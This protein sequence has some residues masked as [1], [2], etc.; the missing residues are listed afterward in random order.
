M[1]CQL[2][3]K[4]L[5]RGK[6]AIELVLSR[7]KNWTESTE[8]MQGVSVSAC[9]SALVFIF[10][11]LLPLAI[12]CPDS[13][14][15]PKLLPSLYSSNSAFCLFVCKGRLFGTTSWLFLVKW[16]WK[17]WKPTNSAAKM[18]HTKCCI[19]MGEQNKSQENEIFRYFIH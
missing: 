4:I 7:R 1:L 15:R 19:I 5:E 17:E 6:C 10:Y 18:P 3:I 12:V 2:C 11:Q 16:P 9:I 13:I 8:I 14:P